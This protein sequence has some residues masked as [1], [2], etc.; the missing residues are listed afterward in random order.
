MNILE[1]EQPENEQTAQKR[2]LEQQ[3][4]P[5][6]FLLSDVQLQNVFPVEIVAKRFPTEKASDP[7]AQLNIETV[8]IDEENHTGEVMLR[9][10]V[11]FVEEPRPFEIAFT[12]LGQFTYDP[13]LTP[14]QA[15]TFLERGSLSVMLPFV[16]ELLLGT[17]TRLQI[18][19]IMLPMIKLAPP[20]PIE[21]VQER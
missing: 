17:C 9:L 18:S 12:V 16:R 6:P 5:L 7:T 14:E 13:T 4:E 2:L 10:E 3:R 20:S 1:N 21:V 11:A 8:N 19:P 15:R